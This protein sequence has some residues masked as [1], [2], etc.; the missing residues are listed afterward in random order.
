MKTKN[1]RIAL[2]LM[3]A[4]NAVV[5][6]HPKTVDFKLALLCQDHPAKDCTKL[7]NSCRE[8]LEKG[9]DCIVI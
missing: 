2:A 5:I 1:I 3:L 9:F 6:P 8:S 7:Q 4:L